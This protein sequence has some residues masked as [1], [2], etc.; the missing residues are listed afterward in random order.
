LWIE[1]EKCQANRKN[2]RNDRKNVR[3]EVCNTMKKKENLLYKQ[4]KNKKK[5]LKAVDNSSGKGYL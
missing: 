1:P 4:E 5:T 3:I 2:V